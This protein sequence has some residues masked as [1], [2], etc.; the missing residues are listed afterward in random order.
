MEELAQQSVERWRVAF[1]GGLNSLVKILGEQ[2]VLQAANGD[3]WAQLESND[4][5]R[6]GGRR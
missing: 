6:N 5:P 4:R 2:F 1:A 3:A